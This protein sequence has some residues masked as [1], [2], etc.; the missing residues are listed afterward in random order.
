VHIHHRDRHSFP[1]RRSSD[2]WTIEG[3]IGLNQLKIAYNH[4][5]PEITNASGRINFG[6]ICMPRIAT[7]YRVHKRLA[8]RGSV[9]KGYSPPT[10]PEV[11]PSIQTINSEFKT[12]TGTNYEIGGRI[13]TANRRLI[14]DLSMYHYQMDNGIVQQRNDR[15]EDYYRNAGEIKQQGIETSVWTYVLVPNR[16]RFIQALNVHSSASYNH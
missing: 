15:A 12:E 7:S 11:P 16:Q 6:R 14:V 13:E 2:L 10:I 5:F 9:S 4:R 8:L 3:S 1:T